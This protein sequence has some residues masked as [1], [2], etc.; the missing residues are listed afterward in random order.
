[1]LIRS[2]NKQFIT[3]QIKVKIERN[4]FNGGDWRISD[5]S[6]VRA[7]NTLG[8]YSSE[9]K[10]IKVLDMI[11]KRYSTYLSLVG[12]PALIQGHLD[13]QPTVYNIP[14]VFQMPQDDEVEA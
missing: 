4:P 13:V 9:A 12:G 1:M 11:E 3:D 7:S 8:F 6:D 14:K 2:Q 10:A 5:V